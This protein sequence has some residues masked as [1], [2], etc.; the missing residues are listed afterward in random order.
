MVTFLLPTQLKHLESSGQQ[1]AVAVAQ[2]MM[3][4]TF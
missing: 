1:V 2:Q 4:K 3:T